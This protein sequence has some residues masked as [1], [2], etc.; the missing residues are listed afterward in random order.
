MA[1]TKVFSVTAEEEDAPP[2]L[3]YMGRVPHQARNKYVQ[4]QTQEGGRGEARFF[5]V[6]MH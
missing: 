4:R 3:K 2:K 1:N 6:A 5:F